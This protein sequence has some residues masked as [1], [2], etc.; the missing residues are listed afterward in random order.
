MLFSFHVSMQIIVKFY[1]PLMEKAFFRNFTSLA[2]IHIYIT[3]NYFL[4][5]KENRKYLYR[6]MFGFSGI[7]LFKFLFRIWGLTL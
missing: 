6:Y 1:I 4:G 3:K 5:L 2:C 7:I